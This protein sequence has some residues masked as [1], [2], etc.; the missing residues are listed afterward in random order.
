MIV[1]F[2]ELAKFLNIINVT[3]VYVTNF[4]LQRT[5]YSSVG[6]Q[7]F[8]HKTEKESFAPLGSERN[9]TMK[10][11]IVFLANVHTQCEKKR[12]FED[13]F[14]QIQLDNSSI[15]DFHFSAWS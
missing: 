11:A 4:A 8:E 9:Q 10:K 12:R 13:I 5:G 2:A 14:R 1:F 6:H 7:I 3:D 15:V